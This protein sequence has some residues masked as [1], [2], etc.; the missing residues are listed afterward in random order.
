MYIGYLMAFKRISVDFFST[1][2]DLKVV[3]DKVIRCDPITRDRWNA[4]FDDVYALCVSRPVQYASKLYE[5]IT[6]LIKNRVIEI[7][8]EISA[9]DDESLL[10]S[11]VQFWLSFHRGLGFLDRLCGFLNTQYVGLS[12]P[13]DTC[14]GMI[15]TGDEKVNMEIMELGLSQWKTYLIE[16]LR[17]RLTSCLLKEVTGHRTGCE[18]QPLCIV[19]CLDSFK[20][21]DELKGCMKTSLDVYQQL[22]EAPL[23]ESTRIYYSSWAER[24]ETSLECTD[25]VAQV[26]FRLLALALRTDETERAKK[27]YKSSLPSIEKLFKDIIVQ[28]RLDFL[29]ASVSTFIK[30]ENKQ[31]EALL[32]VLYVQILSLMNI[33]QLLSPTN[34]CSELLNCFGSHVKSLVNAAIATMPIDPN[35]A[36]SYFVESLLDLRTRFVSFIDEVFEGTSSFRNEMDKAFGQA[37]NSSPKSTTMPRLTALL[38]NVRAAEYLSRYMDTLLRKSPKHCSEAELEAKLTASITL[39]KYIEE[40]DIFRKV[41][42]LVY[43]APLWTTYTSA[44]LDTEESAINQLNKVC[45]YEFTSKFQRMFN[46]IQLAPDLNSNFQRYLSER[47]LQFRFTPHFDVLTVFK[48]TLVN[49]PVVFNFFFFFCPQLSAWPISLKNATEFSL[50]SDLLSVNTHFEEF[51]R[52]AYNGRRLRWAQSH[53][54]TE[55]R[56]CYTDKPYVI[57]L[58]SLNAAVLLLFESLDVDQL[59][60]ADLCL[61]LQPRVADTSQTT[62]STT[63]AP[64]TT[65]DGGPMAMDSVQPSAA[66]P[67]S[68]GPHSA[69]HAPSS[70]LAQS[71]DADALR[72]AVLPLVEANVLSLQTSDSSLGPN[73]L[74]ENTIIALNHNFTSKRLRIKISYFPQTRESAQEE[75]ERGEKE[76]EED[77]RFFT[78]AAI[79]RIMKVRKTCKHTILIKCVLDMAKGR[80]QPAVPLIKRCIENLIEKGYLERSPNDPDQYNYLA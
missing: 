74:S 54:T 25:Y 39:F 22:F 48:H 62:T 57:S 14:Y 11:Y 19:P 73:A 64:H 42:P 16:P 40:K 27:F 71:L 38:S 61:G 46:D 51:Y 55:L 18:L 66:A 59:S 41:R 5:E 2:N 36:P 44:L 76:V 77:R 24:M 79:V 60:V 37:V 29:N 63:T 50:P 69:P 33:F 45:G 53:S 28:Q 34:Q 21:V 8:E 47:G 67:S 10:K 68:A 9:C 26:P 58:S 30:D 3:C 23:L 80:F 35:L 20:Q 75:A 72:R 49:H 12:Q 4:S 7:H 13:V 1:W 43:L 32:L 31:G 56:C 70:S 17:D 15:S 6:L 65:S 78:Q 52:A